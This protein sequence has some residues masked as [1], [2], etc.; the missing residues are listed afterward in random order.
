MIARLP[1]GSGILKRLGESFGIDTGELAMAVVEQHRD[2]QAQRTGG[3]HQ[4]QAAIAV[5]VAGHDLQ[6]PGQ[7]ENRNALVAGGAEP[8]LDPVLGAGESAGA[9]LPRDLVRAKIPVEIVE[10][11]AHRG[12]GGNAWL[13]EIFSRARYAGLQ[14]GG[15]KQQEKSA[16]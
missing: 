14:Q 11:G 15:E 1:T 5:N 13:R 6:A 7:R 12:C 2:R 4:V 16:N 10:G 9:G 8:E 3:E